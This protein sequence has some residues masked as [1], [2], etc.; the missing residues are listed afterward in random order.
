M[1]KPLDVIDIFFGCK[2]I[3]FG[4]NRNAASTTTVSQYLLYLVIPPSWKA[5]PDPEGVIHL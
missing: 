4:V 2:N 5:T 3:C 1:P